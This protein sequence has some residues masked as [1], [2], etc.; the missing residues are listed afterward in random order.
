MEIVSKVKLL[1]KKGYTHRKIA[2]ELGISGTMVNN[3]INKKLPKYSG[4]KT[5]IEKCRELRSNGY[6]VKDIAKKLGLCQSTV[7]SHIKG[8]PKLKQYRGGKANLVAE[9]T[10]QGLCASDI[11]E[12]TGLE[13]STV[14]RY[15]FDMGLKVNRKVSKGENKSLCVCLYMDGYSKSQIQDITSLSELTI[16]QYTKGARAPLS[17]KKPKV[18]PR[19]KKNKKDTPTQMQQREMLGAGIEAGVYT[20]EVKL[21]DNRDEGRLVKLLYSDLSDKPTVSISIRVKDDVSDQEAADRWGKRFG[22]KSW[23]LV[24]V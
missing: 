10:I 15:S 8:M 20:K 12:K 16:Q 14:H 17:I 3:I 18:M 24:C 22:K 23:R 6:L 9:L 13:I 5:N 11:A 7:S 4:K 21:R 1:R 19:K 2:S